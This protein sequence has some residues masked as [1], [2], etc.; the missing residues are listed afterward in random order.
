M[1]VWQRR[2]EG[3]RLVAMRNLS[4]CRR[5]GSWRQEGRDT[6]LERA[7]EMFYGIGISRR[8]GQE[9][10]VLSA[11]LAEG[12]RQ[13]LYRKQGDSHALHCSTGEQLASVGSIFMFKRACFAR[14]WRSTVA[15]RTRGGLRAP[16]CESWG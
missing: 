6:G 8:S 14:Q 2:Q 5:V 13:R 16:L 11:D 3:C 12:N 9:S 10:I 1:G 7:C 4:S 15:A